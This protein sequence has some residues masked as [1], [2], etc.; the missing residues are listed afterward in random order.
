MVTDIAVA[1]RLLEA[2]GGIDRFLLLPGA[3]DGLPAEIAP[4]LKRSPPQDQG[5]L[6][7]LSL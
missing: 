5:D 6:T 4:N 2:G 1:D 3:P 7:R